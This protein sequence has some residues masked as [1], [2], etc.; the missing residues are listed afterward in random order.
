MIV[1]PAGA[2]QIQ[3]D[4]WNKLIAECKEMVMQIQLNLAN[5]LQY[6]HNLGK[7]I[8]AASLHGKQIDVLAEELGKVGKGF[9]RT[10]LYNSIKFAQRYPDFLAFIGEH[11]YCPWNQ[12]NRLLVDHPRT[13]SNA[14]DSQTDGQQPAMNNVTPVRKWI[15]LD[16][17]TIAWYGFERNH[18]FQGD[19]SAFLNKCV[20]ERYMPRGP[21]YRVQYDDGRFEDWTVYP[22]NT[23]SS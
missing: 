22:I 3:E 12:V 19:M 7:T 17:T 5:A 16:P 2:T 1:N 13:K 18:G 23:P 8:V 4:N 6:Y 11:G 15:K 21:R 10:N 20:T 14:L 9:S